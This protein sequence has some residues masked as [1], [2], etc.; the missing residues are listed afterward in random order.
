[1]RY[2]SPTM[3]D[4]LGS[5]PTILGGAGQVASGDKA[6]LMEHNFVVDNKTLIG[7]V[8][9]FLAIFLITKYAKK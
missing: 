2:I 3:Q 6:L 9:A 7:I 5:L 4:T 1:M 8:L